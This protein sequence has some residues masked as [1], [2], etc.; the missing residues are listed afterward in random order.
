MAPDLPS[1]LPENGSHSF[2]TYDEAL[3][4]LTGLINHERVLPHKYSDATFNLEG[5]KKLLE[6]L[7][8]PHQMPCA[9]IAGTKGKG[10]T[11][12]ILASIL[13][14]HGL[15]TGLYTSPHVLAWEE[16][17]SVN[18]VWISK[19]QM[20][21]LISRIRPVVDKLKKASH[22]ASPT[23]FE[24]L[25]AIAWLHF[26]SQSADFAVMETGLGGRLDATNV[27]YPVAC[28]I[29]R[30][31]YDHV[32][33]LGD[34]LEKIAKEKAGII[35]EG[36]SVVSSAQAKEA[37]EA[38]RARAAK[39]SAPIWFVGKDIEVTQ[40]EPMGLGVSFSLRTPWFG[41]NDLFV[42]L[43]GEHQ[44]LNAALAIAL[45]KLVSD[46]RHF[47]LHEESVRRGLRQ[48]KLP[49][50]AEVVS[51]HPLIV[52]DGGHNA[53]AARALMSALGNS[54]SYERRIIVLGIMKDKDIAAVLKELSDVE[55]I[56]A[57][58]VDY[59][60]ATPLD[61]LAELARIHTKA[62]VTEVEGPVKAFEA[63]LSL[64]RPT[65]LVCV[66]GSLYLAGEIRALFP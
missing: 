33:L 49:A 40:I 5:M 59:P 24:A 6:A 25:T 31:D 43:L 11:S 20:R 64:A 4:Y 63:A 21:T 51:S 36:I 61:E 32:N 16:R 46:A 39:L 27:A 7:G 60:R 30:I 42:P 19:G 62:T 3:A 28:G 58:A 1:E 57:T 53:A 12:T 35:K 41:F 38:I 10:S 13:R 56:V 45:A 66:T 2:A 26:R 47:S 23:F 50:R 29:T 9:H 18:G 52:I 55:H 8:S 34:T 17:I 37:E 65:D 15:K 44:A 14:N 48:T 54:L 22:T